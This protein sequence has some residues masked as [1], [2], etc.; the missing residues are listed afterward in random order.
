[1]KEGICKLCNRRYNYKYAL[2]GRGCLNSAYKILDVQ[3]PQKVEDK[4]LYLCNQVARKLHK[5]GLSKKQKYLLTE[6]FLTVKYLGKIKYGNLDEEKRKLNEDINNMAFLKYVT[7]P[8]LPITLNE[9]Y[10]L[11]N[12]TEKFDKKLKES[13]KIL[14]NIDFEQITEDIVLNGM[15]FAFNLVKKK[16]PIMYKVY[17]Y[18]QYE[19]WEVV[20]F[21]G[22]LVNFKLSSKLMEHS[23]SNMNSKPKDII[24]TEPEFIDKIK[25]NSPLRAIGLI[26]NNY[27]VVSMKYGVLKEY[28]VTVNINL[29]EDEL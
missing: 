29:N 6:K 1:M 25:G 8:L 10:K 5:V 20:M 14:N 24:V 18:M 21:G 17:Y 19:F 7:N 23:L 16:N 28:K 22:L 4:E 13:K 27:G 15:Q 12:T 9:A 26:L 11:Y 3:M 2:F